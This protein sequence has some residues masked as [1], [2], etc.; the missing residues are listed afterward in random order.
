LFLDL[1]MHVIKQSEDLVR[2]VGANV[3]VQLSDQEQTTGSETRC[4]Y[5]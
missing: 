5:L 2:R 4:I 1:C 3:A